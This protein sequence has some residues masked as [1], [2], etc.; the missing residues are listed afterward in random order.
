MARPL[1]VIEG[2]SKSFGAL[3]VTDQLNF[4]VE[5]GECHALI[6]PNGAGKTT[7]IGQL[8]GELKPNRG[9]IL[10][11]G[12]DITGLAQAR[13]VELG[14]AR[15]FQITSVFLDFTA[16]DNVILAAQAA[17][18]HNFRFWGRARR[19]P[20]LRAASQRYLDRVG[21]GAAAQS[22]AADLAHG[23]L[24]QLEL[25]MALA[26][27]PKL[28]LLDEPMAGMS[29][30]ESRTMTDLLKSLAGTKTMLLIEHDMDAVFRLADRITVLIGGRALATDRPD[31]IRENALVRTAYLGDGDHAGA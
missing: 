21:L 20:D 5:E 1:L 4:E 18:G 14:I 10:F 23:A 6:G 26:L 15:S 16:Q 3:K 2:L 11:D 30:Q 22:R 12:H 29:V 28:L 24:R 17:R 31:A 9:R 19:H 8:M 25:A 27:E 13:R 7:L